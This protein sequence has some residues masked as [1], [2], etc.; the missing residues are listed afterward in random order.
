MA[1]NISFIITDTPLS[2][3]LGTSSEWCY[4]K[5]VDPAPWIQVDFGHYLYVTCLIIQGRALKNQYVR[6]YELALSGDG[7]TWEPVAD[8]HGTPTRVGWFYT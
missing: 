4:R 7:E 6:N 8:A 3:H 5:S 1:L 2:V